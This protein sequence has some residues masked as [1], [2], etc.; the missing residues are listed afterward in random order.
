MSSHD[1]IA[2]DIRINP[3][4]ARFLDIVMVQVKYVITVDFQ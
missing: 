3:G 4:Q 1:F 2:G